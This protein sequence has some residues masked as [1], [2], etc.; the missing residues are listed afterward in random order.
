MLLRE[1]LVVR[2]QNSVDPVNKLREV[3]GTVVLLGQDKPI[4]ELLSGVG[5][6]DG[7]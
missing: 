7:D 2:L 5:I 3:F 1:L 4:Q 6:I